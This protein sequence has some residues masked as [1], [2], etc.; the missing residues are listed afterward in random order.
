MNEVTNGNS[1]TL[2]P[3]HVKNYAPSHRLSYSQAILEAL[4]EPKTTFQLIEETGI[5]GKPVRALVARLFKEGKLYRSKP[6]ETKVNGKKWKVRYYVRAN[7]GTD[8]FVIPVSGITHRF[9]RYQERPRL[10]SNMILHVLE[11]RKVATSQEIADELGFEVRR[12]SAVLLDMEKRYLVK[13]VGRKS[14]S[15]K[16]VP[17]SRIGYVG[18]R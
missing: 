14:K 2:P 17:I 9:Y 13:K 4:D 11:K 10:T 12:V 15:G 18:L 5:P 7:Q 1:S 8:L 3:V 6:F 16:E